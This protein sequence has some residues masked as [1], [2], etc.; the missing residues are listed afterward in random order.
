MLLLAY[1]IIDDRVSPLQRVL[2]RENIYGAALL[3]S[4][5]L[6]LWLAGILISKGKGKRPQFSPGFKRFLGVTMFLE[7]I[8]VA[9]GF[10]NRS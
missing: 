8:A 6:V 5:I 9:I 7:F 4:A 10:L 2:A 3:S 1:T